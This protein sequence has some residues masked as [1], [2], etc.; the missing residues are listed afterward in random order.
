MM[1]LV[2]SPH[3]SSLCSICVLQVRTTCTAGDAT[4]ISPHASRLY[5]THVVLARTIC[6]AYAAADAVF[7][8]PCTFTR[9]A[10][11]WKARTVT[12]VVQLM[13]SPNTSSL[14][15]TQVLLTGTICTAGAAACAVSKRVLLESTTCTADTAACAVF[16]R[17]G[18]LFDPGSPLAGINYAIDAAA[19][20]V[21]TRFTMFQVQQ[22]RDL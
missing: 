16:E 13:Q 17:L 19:C 1:Q 11:F 3:A 6:A 14:Y 15:L 7:R 9:P 4:G 12:L 20:A 10:F 5:L 21:M 18:P 8:T 22:S 2:Q